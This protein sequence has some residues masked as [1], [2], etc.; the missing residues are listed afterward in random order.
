LKTAPELLLE[1]VK[2]KDKRFIPNALR[3]NIKPT[4]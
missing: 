2:I 4:P 1:K 3:A